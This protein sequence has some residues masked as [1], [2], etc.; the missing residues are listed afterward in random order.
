VRSRYPDVVTRIPQHLIR[1]LPV[2]QRGPFEATNRRLAALKGWAHRRGDWAKY[3]EI[4]DSGDRINAFIKI[5]HLVEPSEY[6]PLLR[7]VWAEGEFFDQRDL[8]TTVLSAHPE[9]RQTMM[10]PREAEALDLLPKII[11]VYRGAGTRDDLLSGFSWTLDRERA[12][13]FS[14][15]FVGPQRLV[16]RGRI[17]QKKVIAL[18][19]ERGE[20]EIVGLPPD[21]D[22]DAIETIEVDEAEASLAAHG[23]GP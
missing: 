17:E 12:V 23:A 14:A 20:R 3:L 19:E 9:R 13:W 10:L 1:A 7:F 18:I 5:C 6:W 21:I 11:D 15:R 2:D 4:H 8:W 16:A 22:V